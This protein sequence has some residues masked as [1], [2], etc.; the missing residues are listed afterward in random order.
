MS[1]YKAELVR[2]NIVTRTDL[3]KLY[4]PPVRKSQLPSRDP[5]QMRKIVPRPESMSN[6][7][8]PGMNGTTG[9]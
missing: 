4:H 7:H 5:F 8:N 2:Q 9:T 3:M 6:L 1:N